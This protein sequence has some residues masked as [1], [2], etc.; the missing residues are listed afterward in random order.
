MTWR[1]S[2]RIVRPGGCATANLRGMAL[3]PLLAWPDSNI[4]GGADYSVDF[5]GVLG[6][7]EA[8]LSYDFD[9]GAAGSVAWLSSYGSC[10]TA[11]ITWLAGGALSVD[12]A[13]LST[14]GNTYQVTV[15][16][17]VSAVPALIPS[18]PQPSPGPVLPLVDSGGMEGWIA[19]LPVGSPSGDGWWL[20]AGIP[21][22]AGRPDSGDPSIPGLTITDGAMSDWLSSLPV[23]PPTAGWW[24]NSGVMTFV[25][26]PRRRSTQ[27]NS[28]Q[29]AAWMASMPFSPPSAGGWWSNA[30][31]PTL[32]GV[33]Q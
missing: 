29:M 15:S 22:F 12:V 27:I 19:C 11:Y 20:N 8:V 7:G 18:A 5:S 24:C 6:C 17:S 21:T 25:G 23:T 14:L 3:Q 28:A 26:A 10:V 16:I 32:T 2:A 4:N 31:I 9:P 13:V 33:I 1:P 30:N